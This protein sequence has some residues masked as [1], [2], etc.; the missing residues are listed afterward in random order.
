MF[1]SRWQWMI[2]LA[3]L[4]LVAV[5]GVWLLHQKETSAPTNPS[6]IGER[7]VD[8]LMLGNPSKAG[9]D[10]NNYLLQSSE[11]LDQLRPYVTSYNRSRNIPQLVKLAVK[12]IVARKFSSAQ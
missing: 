7:T 2:A 9:V 11:S 10:P 3:L 1:K 8:H 6:L 4:A 5:T 12:Q